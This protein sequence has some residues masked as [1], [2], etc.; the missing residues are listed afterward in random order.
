MKRRRPTV[1]NGARLKVRNSSTRQRDLIY[2]VSA[3]NVQIAA[4]S[5]AISIA[6][7][8]FKIPGVVSVDLVQQ[9]DDITR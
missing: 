3:R 8:L 9:T 6:D 7:A 4:D 5:H 1:Q 2:E